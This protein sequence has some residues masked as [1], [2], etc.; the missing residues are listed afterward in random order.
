[1]TTPHSGIIQE[2]E[3]QRFDLNIGL[4]KIYNYYRVLVGLALLSVFL[5]TMIGTRLGTLV[6]GIF[7]T[8]VFS[9]IFLNLGSAVVV[10]FIPRRFFEVQYISFALVAFDIFALTW[11]MYLSGGVG[12][13]LGVLILVAVATGRVRSI[14]R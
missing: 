7:A 4:L 6:P 14:E 13:G 2:I 12:S 1:M 3:R 5:Q 8:V 10:Q 11:M 9:Y